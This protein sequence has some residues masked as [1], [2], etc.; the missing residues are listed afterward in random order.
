MSSGASTNRAHA[1]YLADA[2][3]EVDWPIPPYLQLGGFLS[4]LAK[5]IKDAPTQDA[6]LAIVRE[7]LADAY[8]GDYLAS[9][10]LDRYSRIPHVRDFAHQIDESIRTY[11]C[12]YTFNAITGLLPV[13]EGII[14]KIA[15]SANRAVGPGTKGLND[16]LQAFVEREVQSPHCYGERLVMLEAFRDFVR[17]RLL[18]STKRFVGLNEF[19]RHGILHGLFDDFGQAINFLRLITLLDLLCFCVGMTEGV[20]MFAP[21]STPESLKL[22]AVYRNLCLLHITGNS[23]MK[24]ETGDELAIVTKDSKMQEWKK[25]FLAF[26]AIIGGIALVVTAWEQADY[27]VPAWIL[28]CVGIVALTGGITFFWTR[29]KF[30]KP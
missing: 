17:E 10:F 26:F 14:R 3:K 15:I 9:M 19:N 29:T 21:P 5:A 30:Y 23:A 25:G 11:F 12:G 18:E 16:E 28:Y 22:A 13:I 6:K 4:P 7:R 8:N 24:A 2:F 20:S 1:Q 27:Y